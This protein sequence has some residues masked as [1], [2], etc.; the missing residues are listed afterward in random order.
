MS[1]RLDLIGQYISVVLQ[2][3]NAADSLHKQGLHYQALLALK[4]AIRRLYRENREEEK[5][6]LSW[7]KRIDDLALKAPVDGPDETMRDW[8]RWV[9]LNREAKR[10]YEELDFEIWSRLHQLGYFK[11]GEGLW[12]PSG[13]KRSGKG[14]HK[15]FPLELSSEVREKR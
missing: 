5:Q 10:L 2:S 6:L 13:G 8:K 15:G 7:I 4:D 14:E 3:L 12:F 1:N 9:W 11:M